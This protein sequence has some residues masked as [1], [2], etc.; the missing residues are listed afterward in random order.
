M[1]IDDGVVLINVPSI[2]SIRKINAN[3]P[4]TAYCQLAHVYG[5]SIPT[6][7]SIFVKNGFIASLLEENPRGIYTIF[8]KKK[9]NFNN[10]MRFL[11]EHEQ[12]RKKELKE[13]G[14]N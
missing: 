5:Y 4:F 11:K 1:I 10:I 8:R 7:V 13:L 3:F 14:E 6:L 9:A 2:F 12:R